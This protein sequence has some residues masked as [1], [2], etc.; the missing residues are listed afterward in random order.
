[1]IKTNKNNNNK[2]HQITR[3]YKIK[4]GNSKWSSTRMSDTSLMHWTKQKQ[5]VCTSE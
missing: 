2:G 4:H 5:F 1:M 3:R